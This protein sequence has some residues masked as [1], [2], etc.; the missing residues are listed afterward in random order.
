MNDPSFIAI[1]TVDGH[2]FE[3][4]LEAVGGRLWGHENLPRDNRCVKFHVPDCFCFDMRLLSSPRQGSYELV[5][6][7]GK[8]RQY[9]WE[10]EQSHESI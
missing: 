4:R 5:D 1:E 7:D 9:R 2:E 10:K 6:K 3:H 8:V